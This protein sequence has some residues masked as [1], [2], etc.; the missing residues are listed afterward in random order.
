MG[1]KPRGFSALVFDLF[2]LSLPPSLNLVDCKNRLVLIQNKII[3]GAPSRKSPGR[4]HHTHVCMQAG[5]RSRCTHNTHTHM[6]TNTCTRTHTHTHTYIHTHN[7]HAC[8][9]A[10]TL[11]IKMV[12]CHDY[13]WMLLSAYRPVLCTFLNL[14]PA[15][16]L[17]LLSSLAVYHYAFAR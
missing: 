11:K 9:H 3:Y 14:S 17:A 12:G 8:T 15:H 7:T 6:H 2:F 5:M 1:N 10:H 4:F 13:E 16:F